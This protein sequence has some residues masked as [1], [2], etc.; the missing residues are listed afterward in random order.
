ML[1]YSPLH[2][3]HETEVRNV[4]DSNHTVVSTSEEGVDLTRLVVPTEHNTIEQ[5]H[6]Q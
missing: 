2:L 5:T 6:E 3:R 1:H 4:P